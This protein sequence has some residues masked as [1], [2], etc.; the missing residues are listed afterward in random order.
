MFNVLT[1]LVNLTAK[2]RDWAVTKSLFS[3]SSDWVG[4][5]DEG[6]FKRFVANSGKSNGSNQP[7]ADY[8]VPEYTNYGDTAD[9]HINDRTRPTRV[10]IL[11]T[12]HPLSGNVCHHRQGTPAICSSSIPDTARIPSRTAS[13]S[14]R[15]TGI[16]HN[17]RFWRSI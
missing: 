5:V 4:T 1:L 16:D 11:F 13:D 6:R 2:N 3:N 10:Q 15:R 7:M 12:D 9:L 8:V 17:N 14:S